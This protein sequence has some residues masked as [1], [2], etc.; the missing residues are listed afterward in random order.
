MLMTFP[1]CI[2][3]RPTL[4]NLPSLSL[5]SLSHCCWE[6]SFCN[7]AGTLQCD[8]AAVVLAGDFILTRLQKLHSTLLSF[9]LN[10]AQASGM[11]LYPR[12]LPPPFHPPLGHA[13]FAAIPLSLTLCLCL[14]LC[15]FGLENYLSARRRQK[16]NHIFCFCAL[17]FSGCPPFLSLCPSLS[18]SLPLSLAHCLFLFATCS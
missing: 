2:W 15:L 9:R 12:T 4:A 7:F 6:N 17:Y 10:L 1:M 5:H 16:G 13:H 14:P 3:P 18:L 8:R 11:A